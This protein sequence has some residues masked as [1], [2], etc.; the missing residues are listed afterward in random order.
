[1]TKQN[2]RNDQLAMIHIAKKELG[3]DDDTY[4]AV[5]SQI[6]NGRTQS[7]R[8]LDYGERNKIL[9]HFKGRG[10]KK[11]APKAAKTRP[12][13]TDD[14]SKKIRALW[15][16]LHASGA[17]RDSSENALASYVMR[18]TGVNALQWLNTH[19]ASQVIEALKKWL[20]RVESK[21]TA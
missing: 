13:A 17:L 14:Q 9:E 1:M 3:L 5:I 6:S 2:H 21:V 10:W 15:L 8:D 19:Q 4:R 20:R 18:Q 16:D 7:S 11:A 12:L